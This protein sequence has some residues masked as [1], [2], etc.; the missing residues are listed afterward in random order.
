MRADTSALLQSKGVKRKHKD[1]SSK[2]KKSKHKKVLLADG[3]C[4]DALL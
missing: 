2:S 3:D 1:S 4:V